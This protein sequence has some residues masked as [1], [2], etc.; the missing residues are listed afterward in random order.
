MDFFEKTQRLIPAQLIRFILVHITASAID[1][2]YN[3]FVKINRIMGDSKM[4][5]YYNDLNSQFASISIDTLNAEIVF[6]ERHNMTSRLTYC[7]PISQLIDFYMGTNDNLFYSFLCITKNQNCAVHLNKILKSENKVYINLV[8]SNISLADHIFQGDLLDHDVV[9]FS[10][11]VD[12][13]LL[14]DFRDKTSHSCLNMIVEQ[15]LAVFLCLQPNC[16][17]VPLLFQLMENNHFHF[18]S[19]QAPLNDLCVQNLTNYLANNT[20]SQHHLQN[21]AHLHPQLFKPVENCW[22]KR[23]TLALFRAHVTPHDFY[24][25]LNEKFKEEL[26]TQSQQNTL[27][28]ILMD[29]QFPDFIKHD[30]FLTLFNR[31]NHQLFESNNNY[32]TRLH[33]HLEHMIKTHKIYQAFSDYICERVMENINYYRNIID[34]ST[35]MFYF[36]KKIIKK[37]LP[38]KIEIIMY[39][40]SLWEESLL[41]KRKFL[42]D[43]IY[44][45]NYIAIEEKKSIILRVLERLDHDIFIFLLL[46][47]IKCHFSLE[48]KIHLYCNNTKFTILFNTCEELLNIVNEVLN[49]GEAYTVMQLGEKIG[50]NIDFSKLDEIASICERNE[51]FSIGFFAGAKQEDTDRLL[52]NLIASGHVQLAKKIL[53]T[54]FYDLSRGSSEK[55]IYLYS[56]LVCQIAYNHFQHRISQS[57][58]ELI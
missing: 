40:T 41:D 33:T 2:M 3:Y 11:H 58:Y 46:P 14:V 35:Q 20:V 26:E 54:P 29:D 37:L 18:S 13:T 55:L 31:E 1:L 12:S 36:N 28:T 23:S 43:T 22:L 25:Q 48:Q 57:F 16:P 45:N 30:A 19:L 32:L 6:N 4:I 51:H 56:R 50:Q 10:K 15:N 9:A 53:Q 8:L 7:L 52:V 42:H 34:R 47:F 44:L 17:H 24:F 39:A 27:H 5:D 49:N 38:T 21:L